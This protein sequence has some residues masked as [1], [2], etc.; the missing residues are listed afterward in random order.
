MKAEIQEHGRSRYF[1]FQGAKKFAFQGKKNGKKVAQLVGSPLRN[2]LWVIARSKV[3]RGKILIL[4]RNKESKVIS[5]V[6]TCLEPNVVD[7]LP[8]TWWLNL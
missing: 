3:T 5:L 7:V 1:N 2:K 8:K 4:K 6:L